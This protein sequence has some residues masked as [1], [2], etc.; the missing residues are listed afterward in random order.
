MNAM[1]NGSSSKGDHFKEIEQKLAIGGNEHPDLFLLPE[2]CLGDKFDEAESYD[3]PDGDTFNHFGTLAK[4]YQ[5]Y[6]AAPFLT[7]RDGIRYNSS[8]VFNRMGGACIH[9]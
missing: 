1:V 6:L 4:Q 2:C 9:L 8:V 5:A 7:V 3:A